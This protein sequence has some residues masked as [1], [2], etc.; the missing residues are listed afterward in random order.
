MI[1][2]EI[3][4][5]QFIDLRRRRLVLVLLVAAALVTGGF[6]LSLV[7]SK[8]ALAQHRTAQVEAAGKMTP[9]EEAGFEANIEQGTAMME[10]GLY[11]LVSIAGVVFALVMFCSLVPAERAR[12]T[13]ECVLAKPVTR[14]QFLLGK[15]LGACAMLVIFSVTMS[16]ILIA[17][18][19][20]FEGSVSRTVPLSCVLLFF[21]AMLVGSVGLALSM[22]IPPALAGVLAYFA[23]GEMLLGIT[24]GIAPPLYYLLPSYYPFSVNQ[25]FIFGVEVTLSRVAL[26]AAYALAYSVAMLWMAQ[27]AFRRHDLA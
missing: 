21:Q 15:W 18:H 14:D 11:V 26:L 17:Y 13:A 9:E 7:A 16:A 19:W 25:Q 5:D 23:G 6:S 4:R 3:A 2:L 8:K 27:L 20:H 10:T 24:K 12:G 22:V 1:L